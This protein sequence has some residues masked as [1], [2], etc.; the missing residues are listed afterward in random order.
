MNWRPVPPLFLV[1]VSLALWRLPAGGQINPIPLT[2]T[3]KPGATP[4]SRTLTMD[5]AVRIALGNSRSLRIAAEGVNRARGRVI[6]S[7]AGLMPT[8]SSEVD[9]THLDTGSTITFP[10]ANG[11][12]QTVPIVRQDQKSLGVSAGLPI[13]IMGLIKAAVDQS[14]FN[15]IAARLEFNRV[16]NQVVLDTKNDYYDVLRAKAFVSVADQALK[17]ARDRQTTAELYLKSEVGTKFDVLRAQTEVAN[18]LQNQISAQN[19][20]NLAI[21]T[22]NN[23]LGLDQNTPLNTVEAKEADS[24]S[25]DFGA[26]VSEAYVTRPEVLEDEALIRA[27]EK[28]ITLARRSILPSTSVSYNFNYTPDAGGFAP[29]TRSWAAVARL[30][31]PTANNFLTL[32][33]LCT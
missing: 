1:F 14:H 24:P 6:E 31:I 20:V 27:A 9:Y 26:S 7:K 8:V 10:D 2:P 11:Q 28:G 13:D 29:K 23:I 22:L 32:S 18:A 4:P 17:N 21:A 16:R 33:A 19:R 15:E 3:T 25:R 5:E 12:P 30:S